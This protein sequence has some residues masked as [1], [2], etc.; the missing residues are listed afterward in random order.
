MKRLPASFAVAH[1]KRFKF[2]DE[3]LRALC[4]NF[5][6]SISLD[7]DSCILLTDSGIQS[8]ATM[9]R[10]RALNLSNCR[11]ITSKGLKPVLKSLTLL[12]CLDISLLWQLHRWPSGLVLEALSHL[13][14]H[15][16]NGLLAEELNRIPTVFPNLTLLD[17]CTTQFT[18]SSAVPLLMRLPALIEARFDFETS[19]QR[20]L[21]NEGPNED[22]LKELYTP[23]TLIYTHKSLRKLWVA[24]VPAANPPTR[25]R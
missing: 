21:R 17:L 14:V 25:P 18:A 5:P 12:Q 11:Q 8:L 15:G 10:L 1:S 13:Y 16:C 7:L 9:T 23:L 24:R 19:Y 3:A 6:A 4:T 2:P 22:T 20:M